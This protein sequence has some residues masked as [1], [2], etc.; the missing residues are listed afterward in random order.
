MMCGYEDK[1]MA[2]IL[3]CAKKNLAELDLDPKQANFNASL[4]RVASVRP[5]AKISGG[6]TL[7]HKL[8][9]LE[10]SPP[11]CIDARNGR[12]TRLGGYGDVRM[13]ALATSNR[14]AKKDFPLPGS[15][16]CSRHQ[17]SSSLLPA[18]VAIRAHYGSQ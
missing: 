17:Q 15:D 2:K 8:T 4:R 14:L 10:V 6:S 13:C 9:P 5:G 3:I 11:S 1:S 16:L 7:K 18:Q 12:R